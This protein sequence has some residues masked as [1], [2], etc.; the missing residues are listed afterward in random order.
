MKTKETCSTLLKRYLDN[1]VNIYNVEK[2]EFDNVGENDVYNISAPFSDKEKT[3]IAG[4]VEAR[5]SEDL[6]KRI[7][8]GSLLRII[9]N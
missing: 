8:Y 7:M 9:H 6:K 1:E 4:R 5:D 2:I 3:I